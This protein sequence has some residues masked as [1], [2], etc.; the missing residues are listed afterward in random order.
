MKFISYDTRNFHTSLN[1]V[2][3]NFRDFCTLDTIALLFVFSKVA[4][5]FRINQYF[6]VIILGLQ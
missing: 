3:R 6:N 5:G 1:F 2:A 4:D